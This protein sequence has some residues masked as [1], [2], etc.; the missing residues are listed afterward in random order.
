MT[1]KRDWLELAR[2]L[3]VGARAK[4]AEDRRCLESKQTTR[5]TSSWDNRS[6]AVKPPAFALMQEYATDHADK[7]Q[8][9]PFA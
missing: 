7:T 5:Q 3:A 8:P 9:H 4:L 1:M 2:K 6:C